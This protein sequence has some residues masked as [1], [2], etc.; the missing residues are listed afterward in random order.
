MNKSILVL[1]ENSVIHGLVSSALEMEGV[2]LHHKFDPQKFV[3]RAN[4][5]MPDLILMGK[6]GEDADL[7][8]CRSIKQDARLAEV[9]LVL[10]TASMAQFSAEEM[11]HLRIAGVV[12]KPF[13]ASDLQQQVSKHLDLTDLIGAAYE[14]RQSQQTGEGEE[15]PL[16]N[17]DVL[18][19]EVLG[20]L[21]EGAEVPTPPLEAEPVGQSVV[22]D[23]VLA[24]ALEPDRA[25]EMVD[26]DGQLEPP[27]PDRMES[28]ETL[29]GEFPDQAPPPPPAEEADLEELGASD[30]LE[31]E[32]PE[33]TILEPEEFDQSLTG[34]EEALAGEESAGA[35][36]EIEVEMPESALDMD[37]IDQELASGE[38]DLFESELEEEAPEPPLP[39]EFEESI[40]VSVR[41]MMDLKPVFTRDQEPAAAEALDEEDFSFVPDE[42]EVEAIQTELDQLGEVAL[43]EEVEEVQEQSLEFA[44][45]E[46]VFELEGKDQELAP[47]PPADELAEEPEILDLDAEELE[48]AEISEED[49]EELSAESLEMEEVEEEL[50]PL[51]PEMEP[52]APAAAPEA[53]A[54]EEDVM[55]SVEESAADEEPL[56][57]PEPEVEAPPDM[58][59]AFAADQDEDLLL[60]EELGDEVIDED[61]IIAPEEPVEYPELTPED[62]KELDFL[63]SEEEQ[64]LSRLDDLDEEELAPELEDEE[65]IELDKE[66]EDMIRA[67]LEEERLAAAAMVEAGEE[68]ATGG[69]TLFERNLT[70][71]EEEQGTGDVEVLDS[72]AEEEPLVAPEAPEEKITVAG[73]LGAEDEGELPEAGEEA[74]VW[75]PEAPPGFVAKPTEEFPPDAVKDPFEGD[76]GEG[77]EPTTTPRHK[78]E[79]VLED[80]HTMEPVL[81]PDEESGKADTPIQEPDLG[82]KEVGDEEEW[83]GEL[84]VPE[85]TLTAELGPEVESQDDDLA[86][87]LGAEE[88]PDL[89]DIPVPDEVE[90]LQMDEAVEEEGPPEAEE[91]GQ[92]LT[93]REP[94]EFDDLV[95]GE[96]GPADEETTEQEQEMMEDMGAPPSGEEGEGSEFDDLFSSLQE[97]IAANPEGEHLDDV[98][99]IE[100]L[101]DRVAALTFTL[102]Q[103]ESPFSRAMGIYAQPGQ[104]AGSEYPQAMWGQA[105]VV[106]PPGPEAPVQAEVAAVLG[107]Q[108]TVSLL[109]PDIRAKLG[110]V[111]DEIISVSVRKAVQEEMPKLMERMSEER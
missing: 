40:P 41:H 63:V 18:D 82:E 21:R 38:V 109:D 42:A 104:D 25:F 6:S 90:P 1:D 66:E 69:D 72:A 46:E 29:E 85:E 73:T 101:R 58:E 3:E 64:E 92:D 96:T 94:L 78:P 44:E 11:D 97:E 56:V 77:G 16:A 54:L 24:E 13:E 99:R 8:L 88:H 31:E 95:P 36:E 34:E 2:S 39:E 83:E 45:Q 89:T 68:E 22:E 79:E 106:A 57:V 23:E 52:P 9:P 74:E 51:E 43:D 62:E 59:P 35:L 65:E 71:L 37:A 91:P 80:P 33:E 103:N 84:E 30:I 15:N 20:M 17:L 55:A 14:F 61:Q 102:P 75:K 87:M 7:S 5:L 28:L 108:A 98:L 107:S 93:T 47:M 32:S 4:S 27:S 48:A 110:Q 10:V 81:Q 53:A 76:E 67:S 12:R 60:A 26:E 105:G 19:D 49:V 100:G 86:S 111:L 50:P 70:A